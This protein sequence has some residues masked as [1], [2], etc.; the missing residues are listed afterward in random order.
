MPLGRRSARRAACGRRDRRRAASARRRAWPNSAVVARGWRRLRGPSSASASLTRPRLRARPARSPD[1]AARCTAL[2][3]RSGDLGLG[4][5]ASISTQRSGSLLG[6]L[7]DRRRAASRGTRAPRPRS[8]RLAPA[9]RR[10]CARASPTSAGT[11]RMKVRS[12][13]RS[14]TVDALERRGSARIDVAEHALIDAGRIGE[15]V[16]D[17]P[18]AA[19]ER[20]LDACCGRGRRARPRTASP[21]PRRRAAWRR[22]TA[23]RGGSISAPGE[24]PGSRVSTT[25]MPSALQ[26]LG[27]QRRVGRLAG[28]LA[29]FE[30]DETSAHLAISRGIVPDRPGHGLAKA[31]GCRRGT[32]RSQARRPRRRRAG[33]I[34]RRSPRSPP[35]AA[36]L[37][38]RRVAAPDLQHADLLAL[39]RPARGTGPV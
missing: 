28:A 14:P 31:S 25:P 18:V 3:I 13:L 35:P 34:G 37:R 29:A 26:A 30:G 32:G 4:R 33:E 19:R 20:R 21:R 39:L 24:P 15:A 23:A 7:A 16:A 36:A 9:P 27:Q 2:Q 1:G 22:P 38:A 12:G 10:L 8:G 5:V 17:H 11:S 6:E